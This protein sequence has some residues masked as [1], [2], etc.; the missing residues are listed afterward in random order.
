MRFT[1]I[2]LFI[3]LQAFSQH[4]VLSFSFLEHVISILDQIPILKGDYEKGDSSS[5]IDNDI[6]QA[7]I[8][9]LTAFFRSVFSYAG[10]IF[11]PG[12]YFKSI[13]QSIKCF[14]AP[15]VLQRWW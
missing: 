3:Y 5:H 7:A 8:F 2:M 1:N 4:T 13:I 15:S 6:L 12:D 9:A 11:F 14:N 10:P